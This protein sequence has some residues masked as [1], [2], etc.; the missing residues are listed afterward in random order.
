MSHRRDVRGRR[1]VD[2]LVFDDNDNNN[3]DNPDSSD[4]GG[5]QHRGVRLERAIE[6]ELR[7]M[8]TD[9]VRDARLQGVRV[10][11]V[12]LSVD[13]RNA[14]VYFALGDPKN[15]RAQG[16]LRPVELALERCAGFLR[17]GLAEALAMDRVPLLRFVFE[18]DP[19]VEWLTDSVRDGGEPCE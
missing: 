3:N 10:L 2:A 17:A 1:R 13:Y 14:R 12:E 5:A 6:R 19:P 11:R 9:D 7:S 18:A 16:S 4:R 8:M 15:E